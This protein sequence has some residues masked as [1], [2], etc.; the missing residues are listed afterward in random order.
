MRITSGSSFRKG[1]DRHIG[2]DLRCGVRMG[3]MF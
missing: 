3:W 1:V 2:K